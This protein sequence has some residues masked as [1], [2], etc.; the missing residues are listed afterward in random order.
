MRTFITGHQGLLGQALLRTLPSSIY[1]LVTTRQQLEL[2]DE[3][4]VD[5]FL[6]DNGVECVILSAAK[7]GGILSNSVAKSE[8]L[9]ENLK[10]QN[11]VIS[12]CLRNQIR[13]LVF[14]GSSCVYPSDIDPPFTEEVLGRGKFESTNEGYAIAKFAGIKLCQSISIEKELCYTSLIPCNLYG[15]FDNFD[16]QTAHVIPALIKKFVSARNDEL[17]VIEIMGSGTARREFLF[18]EDL[19]Q[20]IWFFL[21]KDIEGGLLNIGAG[22][23]ISIKELAYLIARIVGFRGSINFLNQGL[24]GVQSKLMN[25]AR[26]NQLGWSPRVGLEEGITKTVQWFESS[27]NM[28]IK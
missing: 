3:L 11:S 28:S 23:E 6:A 12:S 16:S 4:A 18:S 25:S 22:V 19:A 2:T 13:N 5:R 14:I 7:V 17:D 27:K 21:G 26:A 9:L 1:P 8:Y 24:N 15:P 20:A 10:I